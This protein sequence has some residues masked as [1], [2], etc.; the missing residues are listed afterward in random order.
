MT[1]RDKVTSLSRRISE[2]VLRPVTRNS[3]SD[4]TNSTLRA[5]RRAI[6]HH[7]RD[8]GEDQFRRLWV[9]GDDDC[10]ANLLAGEVGEGERHENDIAVMERLGHRYTASPSESL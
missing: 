2:S 10:G 9:R 6:G 5:A 4:R 3:E 7:G 1:A 8:K